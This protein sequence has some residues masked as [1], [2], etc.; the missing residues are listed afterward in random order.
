MTLNNPNPV[1]KVMS[2]ERQLQWNI[3][4]DLHT[5]YWTV[6]FWMT[7]S[8]LEWLSEIFDDTKHRAVSLRQTSLLF[9]LTIMLSCITYNSYA[10]LSSTSLLLSCRIDLNLTIYPH[11]RLLLLLHFSCHL[12]SLLLACYVYDCALWC[13]IKTHILTY[14]YV[15]YNGKSQHNIKKKIPSPDSQENYVN[16]T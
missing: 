8:D 11:F 7:L 13:P 12:S 4:R 1:V 15:H 14:E 6:S 16:I 10:S 2:S 3:N 5:S 9:C